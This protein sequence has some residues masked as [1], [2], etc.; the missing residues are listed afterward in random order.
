MKG[1]IAVTRAGSARSGP[2]DEVVRRI[3][4]ALRA[5]EQHV[6]AV[7]AGEAGQARV[8]QDQG[9]GHV[10][11][12]R[13]GPAAGEAGVAALLRPVVVERQVGARVGI[14]AGRV[15]IGDAG[16]SVRDPRLR[17]A[18]QPLASRAVGRDA[19]D[20]V[21]VVEQDRAVPVEPAAG[22]ET[23][24]GDDVGGRVVAGVRELGRQGR[25][26]V[27]PFARGD[28]EAVVGGAIP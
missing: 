4:E 24:R 20:V 3:V 7:G 14:D 17:A 28:V 25:R 1:L 22:T 11:A 8:L 16:Q 12:P 9:L 13:V 18:R 19:P 6:G 21:L 27:M 15:V 5:V 2:R 10:S 23:V 26:H